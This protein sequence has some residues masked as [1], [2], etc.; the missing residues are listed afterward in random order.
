MTTTADKSQ[1]MK[2]KAKAAASSAADQVRTGAQDLAHTASE[3]AANYADRAKGA[4]ADEVKGVSHALRAAADDL[5]S[6]SPQERTFSQFADGLA[7]ASDAIR[8]KDLGEIVGTVTDFARR[9]PLTF[10][11]GAA[12]LGF[13]ATRFVKSSSTAGSGSNTPG[14]YG[15]ADTYARGDR[16][17][18]PATVGERPSPYTPARTTASA[19][20]PA[21]TTTPVSRPTTTTPG[22]TL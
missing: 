10:L 5:R 12:L 21:T 3:E 6:G 11:G 16:P 17:D 4:A 20:R 14:S 15:A 22:E 13:A 1:D 18:L 9:N 19:A 2:D 7:D 8:D